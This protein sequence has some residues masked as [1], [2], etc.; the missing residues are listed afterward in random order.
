MITKRIKI[1]RMIFMLLS[2]TLIGMT[3]IG[4]GK[5][6]NNE[7]GDSSEKRQEI[8]K[9]DNE[10]SENEK[11]ENELTV[12][13]LYENQD[14]RNAI[15]MFNNAHSDIHINYI[16]FEEEIDPETKL[17][18]ELTTGNIP[19]LYV[20]DMNGLGN[21]TLKD[22]IS[23]GLFE[24]IRPYIE[25][26][27][28]I[29]EDDIYPSIFNNMLY[30]DGLYMTCGFVTLHTVA[31]KKDKYSD[32]LMEKDK[33]QYSDFANYLDNRN[34]KAAVFFS[35]NNNDELRTFLS[36]SMDYF[37]DYKNNTCNLNCD[38][39][40]KV[41]ELSK[42]G[43]CFPCDDNNLKRLLEDD[44]V[45]CFNIYG[46]IMDIQMAEFG[47]GDISDINIIGYPEKGT[48][49]SYYGALAMSS[50]C[51]NK[52]AAWEFM[53][54]LLTEEYGSKNYTDT[55]SNIPVR[56]DVLEAYLEAYRHEGTFTDIFGNE[57][58]GKASGGMTMG[59]LLIQNRIISEKEEK[60]FYN[61]LDNINGTYG[62]N[63][64]VED[65]IV[66]EAG[67]YFD[68]NKTAEEVAEIVQD[69]VST[70]LSEQ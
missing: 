69:K 6:G 50:E 31:V 55:L 36:F 45:L 58:N 30:D 33:I 18:T 49:V 24:N 39:F 13:G 65:I 25:K 46:D 19:D 32:E 3:F 56:K 38:D 8:S 42:R 34:D 14:I 11:S 15:V 4:C 1:A 66:E 16:N 22:C 28:E 64:T 20:I 62:C 57:A 10:K 47:F 63:N 48:L 41:L 44:S 29:S 12:M 68:G 27:E 67:D 51:K 17:A 52:E 7:V 59:D 54:I 26:D 21:L 53:R 37:I 5:N 35:S 60:Y 61:I 40:K 43:E 70:Y 2:L 23:K 9:E